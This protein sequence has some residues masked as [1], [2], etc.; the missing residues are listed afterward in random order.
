MQNENIPQHVGDDIWQRLAKETRPLV[1][2]GMGNGADKLIARLQRIQKTPAAIFASDDFVRG[3][4]F[5]GFRVCR[6]S[7]ICERYSDFLILASF[8]TRVPDVMQ[9]LFTMADRYPL[10][11]PDMP[12]VG[13]DDFTAALYR[14]DFAKIQEVH[15]L[16]CDGLSQTI[17]RSVLSYKLTGDI[18]YLKDAH[19]GEEEDY[20]C[21]ASRIIRTAIDGGAYTGDTAGQMLRHFP[22]LK[23][24]YAIEPDAKNFKKLE[25]YAA[26]AKT[27]VQIL[28][29]RAALWQQDGEAVFAAAG[30]RNSSL[31]AASYEHREMPV[32]LVTIDTLAAHDTIDYIKWDV[33][34]AEREAILGAEK[35]IRRD[36]PALAVSLYHRSTDIFELPL[37][38]H[39]ISKEYRFYLRRTNCLPAWEIMLYAV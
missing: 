2:Y 27:D 36:H 26:D 7:E 11:L 18:R 15:D 3:Q 14:R 5:H 1:I 19:S 23:K 4:S 39:Q 20:A 8:G 21:L 22:M 13:E 28:P 29:V 25:K 17:Y 9:T 38:I 32:P 33:E 24:L 37:L 6:F 16:L 30:N 12:V 10:L 34:G 35:I 31:V